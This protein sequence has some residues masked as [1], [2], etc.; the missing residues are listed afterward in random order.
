MWREIHSEKGGRGEEE[1]G[2]AMKTAQRIPAK[3][4]LLGYL[5]RIEMTNVTKT[6]TQIVIFRIEQQ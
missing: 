2:E 5:W 3:Q 4:R 6:K 1:E